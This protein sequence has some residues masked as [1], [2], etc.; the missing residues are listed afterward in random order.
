MD[1]HRVLSCDCVTDPARV[2]IKDPCPV[3][4]P[5]I[6]TRVALKS[7]SMSL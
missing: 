2:L 3:G 7:K 6:R 1:G 5:G 4:L